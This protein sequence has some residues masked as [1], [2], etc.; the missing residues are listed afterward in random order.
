MESVVLVS[1]GYEWK[2]LAAL[3][4][5]AGMQ[6]SPF[7]QWFSANGVVFLWGGFG[8]IAAAASAQYAIGHWRP[9][10]VVN[11]G[12]CGG[13]AGE[14]GRGEVLLAERT[15]V[16]DIAERMTDP[17][18]AI[19][20]YT[21]VLDLSWLPA[22]LPQPVRRATLVSADGDLDP[23]DI[24][25]L[26]ARYG[27]VAADWESGAIAWVAARNG[28]RCLILRGVSDLVSAGGGEAYSDFSVY[29]EGSAEVMRKLAAHLPEWMA[30]AA[31]HGS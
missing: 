20:H 17:D 10:L 7:G 22:C 16:Y 25:R 27:A 23:R 24:P 5:D 1:C 11:I 2:A 29:V 21:T 26:K 30:A 9:R 4:P 18:A 8:K 15:V 12:T 19:A 3:F 13:F 28:V 6:N 31:C 14:I